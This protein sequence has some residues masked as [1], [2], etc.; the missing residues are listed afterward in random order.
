MI[1]GTAHQRKLEQLGR[2][3]VD[4]SFETIIRLA[5]KTISEKKVELGRDLSSSEVQTIIDD[6]KIDRDDVWGIGPSGA[7]SAEK[8]GNDRI[9]S[10]SEFVGGIAVACDIEP[11]QSDIDTVI[12]FIGKIAGEQ[13]ISQPIDFE[14]FLTK[15]NSLAEQNNG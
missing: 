12:Y 9:V 3:I 11:V 13:G 5:D 14:T 4:G 6:F 15:V 8:V 1:N 10:L 2:D 7:S